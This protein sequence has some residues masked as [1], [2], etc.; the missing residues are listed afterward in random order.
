MEIESYWKQIYSNW[1][2]NQNEC[3][4]CEANDRTNF[5][6]PFYGIG[7]NSPDVLLLGIDPGGRSSPVEGEKVIRY[8]KNEQ[9]D[10]AFEAPPPNKYSRKVDI[11]EAP[12]AASDF[13][14]EVQKIDPSIELAYTNVKKC[15]EIHNPD[16]DDMSFSSDVDPSAC[17]SA[18][19]K[20]CSPAYLQQELDL[21][22]PDLICPFGRAKNHV[23]SRAQN[24]KLKEITTTEDGL[25]Q[26]LQGDT[27]VLPLYHF[28]LRNWA[29]VRSGVPS[30]VLDEL[31]KEHDHSTKHK[32]QYIRLVAESV[33]AAV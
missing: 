5:W 26:P 18:G 1:Y 4:S 11:L 25:L 23:L 7:S 10:Y 33:C 21:L 22:S 19:T 28:A 9:R 14:E 17:N 29:E 15:S 2:S 3:S 16:D 30:E 12:G 31:G 32:E 8:Y 13:V 20:Q 24:G 6:K 27:P